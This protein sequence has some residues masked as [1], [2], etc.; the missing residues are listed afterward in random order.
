M[1]PRKRRGVLLLTLTG[2]CAIAVFL[3]VM[4]YVG[5]VSSQ[6]GPMTS[7]VR[8]ARDVE[9]YQPIEPDMLEEVDVP[10]RW[11]ADGTVSDVAA[12]AG[13]V[14]AAPY[15]KGATVQAGMLIP[16]PGVQPGYREVAIIVDAET[17]VAGKVSPGDHVDIIATVAGS[18]QEERPR[19]ELWVSNALVLE[20]GL[21]T[22]TE[23]EGLDGTFTSTQG[24]PVTFALTTQDAL[25]LAYG[26]SFSV[27]LRL[28]LRGA[29][30]D[31]PTPEGERVFTVEG[32]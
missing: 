18:Q 1:N 26:E 6:V 25:R 13:L 32:T 30:D 23:R 10:E 16:R 24:V 21:P 7:V 17:G 9:A 31:E 11:V 22:D 2:V 12:T 8:L 29:G 14:A 3:G 5:S 4:S 28:A 20:V 27:K 19:S 15:R